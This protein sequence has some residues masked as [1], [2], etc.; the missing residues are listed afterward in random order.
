MTPASLKNS[1]RTMFS[2]LNNL[3]NALSTANFNFSKINHSAMQSF[4]GN[5]RSLAV[6]SK[7]ILNY[8]R[9]VCGVHI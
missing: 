9:R 1:Y 8:D 5:E 2:A 7:T 3:Y 4:L 6:A